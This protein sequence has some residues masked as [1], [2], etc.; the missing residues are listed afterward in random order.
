MY[1]DDY[2]ASLKKLHFCTHVSCSVL[3]SASIECL[4]ML[5]SAGCALLVVSNK[6]ACGRSIA[7]CPFERIDMASSLFGLLHT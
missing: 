3:A 2:L 4:Y 1:D 5:L 6:L 7:T